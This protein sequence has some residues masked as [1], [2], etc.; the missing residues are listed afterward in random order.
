MR[1]LAGTSV[2]PQGTGSAGTGNP[3][4]A[5]ADSAVAS[6]AEL[7]LRA[8]AGSLSGHAPEVRAAHRARL[9]PRG[10]YRRWRV[11]LAGVH[12]NCPLVAPIGR[13]TQSPARTQ[14]PRIRYPIRA[15]SR[16]GSVALDDLDDLLFRLGAD[17]L[18]GHLPALE[19]QQRGNAA[20]AEFSRRRSYSHPR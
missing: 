10:R 14:K 11:G 20:D 4:I 9:R 19:N 2:R 3:Q 16:L 5:L 17:D 15:G 6:L 7:H 13:A 18:V 12:S 1:P 8:P